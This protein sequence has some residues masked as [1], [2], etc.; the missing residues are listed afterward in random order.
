VGRIQRIHE[1]P[2]TIAKKIA[3]HIIEGCPSL[4]NTETYMF[5]S[6]LNGIG[7][8]VDILVIYHDIKALIRIKE[9]IAKVSESLPLHVLYLDQKEAIETDFV[10]QQRCVPLSKLARS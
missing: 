3:F 6:T 2:L 5:G 10:V 8:D 9:E 4:N 7:H 1:K